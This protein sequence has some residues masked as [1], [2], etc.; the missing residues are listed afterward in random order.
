LDGLVIEGI[1]TNRD[2]LRRLLDHPAFI[3]GQTLT[4]FIDTHRATLF[5]PKT[6]E[7]AA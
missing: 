5:P 6:G 3:A 7:T 1:V 2:F 4:G